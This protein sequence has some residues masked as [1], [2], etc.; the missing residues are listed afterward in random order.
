MGVQSKIAPAGETAWSPRTRANVD[1]RGA[2]PSEILSARWLERGAVQESD[3]RIS[4][5]VAL[6]R[7]EPRVPRAAASQGR[8]L[9]LYIDLHQSSCLLVVAQHSTEIVVVGGD[10]LEAALRLKQERG[11][12]PAVLNMASMSH[13][14]GGYERGAGAQEGELAL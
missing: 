5:K 6:L 9:H 11:L 10:C 7:F 2:A 1:Y 13:P 3:G 4:A 8:L 12:N 14:G